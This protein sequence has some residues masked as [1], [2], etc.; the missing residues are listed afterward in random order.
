MDITPKA[1][2]R[3]ER[4]Y[5]PEPTTGC[6]LW[7]SRLDRG[8]Y[9]KFKLNGKDVAPHRFAYEAFRGPIPPGLQ[10]D[11]KCRVRC[12]V[13]PDHLEPVTQEENTRRAGLTRLYREQARAIYLDPRAQA[14]IARDYGL[15]PNRVFAIKHRLGW[16]AATEDLAHIYGPRR[17]YQKLS[18]TR[19]VAADNKRMELLWMM[20]PP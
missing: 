7:I 12:C 11:H 19:Q 6:H 10:L 4:L 16:A 9:G 1:I 3:F 20:S 17:R 18:Q 14:A 8:N 15:S 5:I 13:N 2:A